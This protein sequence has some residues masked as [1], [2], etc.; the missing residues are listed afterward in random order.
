VVIA[1][2]EAQNPCSSGAKAGD[3]GNIPNTG[4][5]RNVA[6]LLIGMDSK[7]FGKRWMSCAR[8]K[9]KSIDYR[10]C[11]Y[12]TSTGHNAEN[13]TISKGY[14]I[15]TASEPRLWDSARY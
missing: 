10:G 9:Q 13:I 7:Y 14:T 5:A 6:N 2:L 3:T 12:T 15:Y 4:I 8:S 1:N 11:I